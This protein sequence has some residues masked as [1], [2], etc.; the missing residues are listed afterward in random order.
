MTQAS[1]GSC[2]FGTSTGRCHFCERFATSHE[3]ACVGSHSGAAFDGQGFAGQH[4]MVEQN[5]SLDQPHICG[6]NAA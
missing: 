4:G 6:D 1:R 5:R 2:K 3:C